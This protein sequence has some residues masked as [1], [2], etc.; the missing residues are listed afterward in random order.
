MA[1]A[2]SDP[3]LILKLIRGAKSAPVQ[4]AFVQGSSPENSLLGVARRKPGKQI[5]AAL[6]K[7]AGAAK[8]CWG[9]VSME[10]GQAVFSCEKPMSGFDKHLVKW[11]RLKKIRLKASL[12]G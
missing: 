11:L 9:S 6:K 3:V 10:G 5:Y 7:E 4:F 1:D 12:A 2:F 8:G